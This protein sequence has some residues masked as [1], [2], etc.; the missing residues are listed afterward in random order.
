MHPTQRPD[1][2]TRGKCR[3]I[4]SM[5][6]RTNALI[7]LALG[8]LL[9]LFCLPGSVFAQ[10]PLKDRIMEAVDTSRI[11]VVTGN[12]H[13]MAHR[14]QDQGRVDPAMRMHVT[15]I[16]KMTA[17]Q[18]ADLDALLAAQ[19]KRGSPD[20]QRWLTP[21]EFGNRFG[22]SQ[23]DI[24]KVTQWLQGQG[25]QVEGV[26]ASRNMIMFSGTAQQ[27]E[28]A[29]HTEIHQYVADGKAH[30]ANAG[31]PAVPA[32]LSDVVMGFRGL[33]NFELKPRMLKQ[34]SA[35]FTSSVSHNHYVAPPDFATI[36][37]VNHLYQMGFTGSGQKIVVV[38][39]S[40]VA[41]SDIRAFRS[42]SGLPANDPTPV[43][44]NN[45]AFVALIVPGD[46][47]PKMQ[48]GDIDE[49]NLD[50]EWAGAIAY[51]AT[52]IFI[53]GD[54]VNGGGV[55]GAINYAIT[56]SPIPA[57]VI[58]T[59]YGDCEANFPASVVSSLQFLM[60]QANAEGITV[61][62]PTGDTGAADCDFNSSPTG[63]VTTASTHGLAV[64]LPGAL[65]SVTAVGGTEFNEG[66]GTYWKPAVGTDLISSAN[67]YI[68]EEAWNDTTAAVSVGLSAGGGGASTVIAK[69]AWQAGTGVPND[70]A[71]DVPDVS[72]NS[73]LLHDGYLICD[74]KF[75]SSTNTF[76]PT[77]VSPFGFRD[78]AG[79]NL[80]V[81]GGT[82]VGPPIMA[83]IVALINQFTRAAG[84]GNIN[85]V[86][87][88]LAASLPTA[89]HD[90]TTG[91]NQVPFSPPCVPSTQ[92]GY[93]AMPGYDLATGLG[94]I[95]AFLLVTNWTSVAPASTGNAS[96]SVDF[97]LAFTPNQVTVKRGTCGS[98]TL[99]L[100]RLNGFDGTPSFTCTVPATLGTT[101][102][103]VVPAISAA[104]NVPK[105]YRE[106][107]WWGV[108][109][110]LFAGSAVAVVLRGSDA[111][112]GKSVWSSLVPGLAMVTVLTLM[113]G[114][115]GSSKSSSNDPV[116]KYAFA[117]QVP[118]TAP[119]AS[120]AV[121]VTAAIGG[122][123]HTAQITVGIQ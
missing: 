120:A 11:T 113:I 96:T 20:Y 5:D 103:A 71:R 39:Q 27:V 42:N 26:P 86:L 31:D 37:D 111:S 117:V 8:V 102:C 97:S 6:T 14:G 15:M 35:K 3:H 50:V 87:Y 95:D 2:P 18:Q 40:D 52:V 53:V 100:T 109:A 115:G 36:Y 55:M 93:A 49:A 43:D 47:D 48:Q 81:V 68:P 57:P 7:A 28:A 89:F 99:T 12:V 23:A 72:F 30:F 80:A 85:P 59:S 76:S 62:A 10:G 38:G 61:L 114:C 33:N 64:D 32:A 16:F 116:V 22:L 106:L 25:F 98:G 60:K 74:E 13:P 73:S 46:A 4:E 94:S 112:G 104:F 121:N 75:D 56:T 29:L 44:P 90:V 79:G 118:A 82:S 77:C 107:G 91:N 83:S 105:N 45:P 9:G 54:P 110:L 70:G 123:S 1:Y 51:N 63:P 58:S 65:Q 41:L 69:A 88:P 66:N 119:V 17:A 92:I 78:S 108:M 21:E 24:N 84:S 34:T 67:S 19:Q 122:I 101:T